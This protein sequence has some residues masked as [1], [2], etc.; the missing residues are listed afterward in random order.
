MPRNQSFIVEQLD[1]EAILY[2]E[3]GEL[4]LLSG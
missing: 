4:D 3:Q 1:P 2:E